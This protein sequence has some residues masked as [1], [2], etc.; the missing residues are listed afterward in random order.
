[1]IRREEGCLTR[2]AYYRNN[3]GQIILLDA[4]TIETESHGKV[5][6]NVGEGKLFCPLC[7]EQ[8]FFSNGS[9]VTRAGMKGYKGPHFKHQKKSKCA[10]D[11]CDNRVKEQVRDSPY[12]SQRLRVPLFL[13]PDGAG[14][15][16]LSIGFSTVNKEALRKL[17]QRCFKKIIVR[18]GTDTVTE[19]PIE[20]FL[21]EQNM[22][23]IDVQQMV[24]KSRPLEAII[25]NTYDSVGKLLLSKG[26]V[27]W[28]DTIDYFLDGGIFQYS[29]GNS[30]EKLQ[31]GSLIAAN[32]PYLIVEKDVKSE[33]ISD[34][35]LEKISKKYGFLYQKKGYL[36]FSKD[37]SSYMVSKVV[38]PS[39]SDLLASEYEELF[40]WVRERFGVFLYDIAKESTP[41]WPPAMRKTDA[42][43]V[44]SQFVFLSGSG[45]NEKENLTVYKDFE[46]TETI[47]PRVINSLPVWNIPL[48]T[49]RTP[50]TIGDIVGFSATTTAM[51]RNE[52]YKEPPIHGIR[53]MFTGTEILLIEAGIYLIPKNT[54]TIAL[55]ASCSFTIYEKGE[56]PQ[57]CDAGAIVYR[58]INSMHSLFLY[59]CEG[60]LFDISTEKA[61]A[62]ET[63]SAKYKYLKYDKY[64]K[65]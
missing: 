55:S 59:T 22:L 20:D 37:K 7:S 8:V 60:I 39:T 23:Y 38:F 1:M 14:G 31:A 21:E 28:A 54:S 5:R 33:F 62:D 30:G 44:Q 15:F 42:Y 61:S 45:V 27:E 29:A 52:S 10:I 32:R 41:L 43:G 51:Y 34:N 25:Q 13:R 56:N 35:T 49:R 36:R 9:D 65:F 17:Q 18:Q 63:S 11:D 48:F 57:Q 40:N 24:N 16:T 53:L 46:R 3:D 19:V 47:P 12:I 50:V 4:K 2:T 64:E 58:R 26:N 6:L